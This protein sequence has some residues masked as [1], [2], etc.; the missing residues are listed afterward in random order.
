MPTLKS[1]SYEDVYTYVNEVLEQNQISVPEYQLEQ[2]V[3][4]VQQDVLPVSTPDQ[5]EAR[6]IEVANEYLGSQAEMM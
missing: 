3:A 4:D 6:I 1:W 2:V 5:Y